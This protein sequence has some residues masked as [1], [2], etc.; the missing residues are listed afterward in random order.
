MMSP[1][2]MNDCGP[3]HL[4]SSTAEC[5]LSA[6][7]RRFDVPFVWN[8]TVVFVVVGKAISKSRA[9]SGSFMRDVTSSMTFSIAFEWKVRHRLSGRW[10]GRAKGPSLYGRLETKRSA[11]DLDV[12]CWAVCFF[13]P[14][15]E[16][17]LTEN[18]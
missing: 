9:R 18:R 11:A 16:L 12:L 17:L 14:R 5:P 7:L 8:L 13:P 15:T 1:V 2:I 6:V 4:P 10:N 3:S